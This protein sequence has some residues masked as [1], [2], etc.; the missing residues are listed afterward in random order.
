MN[1]CKHGT[2]LYGATCLNCEREKQSGIIDYEAGEITYSPVNDKNKSLLISKYK[3][4][5]YYQLK[6]DQVMNHKCIDMTYV[7]VPDDAR[8]KL[9]NAI[10]Q[11]EQAL[12]L[13]KKANT[14]SVVL[15]IL[16]EIDGEVISS[17]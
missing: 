17:N 5:R 15:E 9:S 6:I 1:N 3:R 14:D 7:L 2:V 10:D 11:I 4:L 8:L 12:E 16:H 13:I